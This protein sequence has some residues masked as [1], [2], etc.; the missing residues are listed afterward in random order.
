MA[1]LDP[2][3]HGAAGSGVCHV[4]TRLKAGHDEGSE[5][6]RLFCNRPLAVLVLLA[7]A[8]AAGVWTAA[9]YIG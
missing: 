1:G 3:C 2:A 5:M 8:L 9:E 6:T 4:D 7:A